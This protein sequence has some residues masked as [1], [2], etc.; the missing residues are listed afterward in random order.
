MA[1]IQHCRSSH[2]LYTID[3]DMP[4]N[5]FRAVILERQ[6]DSIVIALIPRSVSHVAAGALE[7]G[8]VVGRRPHVECEPRFACLV[9]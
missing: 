9:T 3:A 6:R 1:S 8:Q 4:H 7:V 5:Q 2:L